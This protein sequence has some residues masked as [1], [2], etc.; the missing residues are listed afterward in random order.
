MRM[1]LRFLF[2]LA[3]APLLLAGC[4]TDDDLA[5]VSNRVIV[6][7]QDLRGLTAEVSD[8]RT[9][10][11]A[12]NADLEGQL[13]QTRDVL[14][15]IQLELDQMRQQLQRLTNKVEL[16]QQRGTT[17]DAEAK[18]LKKELA[19][20]KLRLDRIEATLTLPP[21]SASGQGQGE[22]RL[23]T[24]VP[25]EPTP[26]SQ[27]AVSSKIAPT[28]EAEAKTQPAVTPSAAATTPQAAYNV[29]EN[30]FKKGLYDPA[31]Q[32]FKEFVRT[33]PQSDLAPAA[34]FFAGECLYLQLKF[35]EAIL[36]YQEVV[37]KYKGNTRVS[38]ALL[39]QALAFKAIGDDATYRL[40]LQQIVKE[41]PDSYSGKE[42]KKK[43]AE[44]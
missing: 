35:E 28:A 36:E 44:R 24:T 15:D 20:A 12:W 29:A 9:K 41:Y 19:A 10:T 13:K 37:K 27:V 39:K 2:L 17:S 14:P 31:Y 40:L 30:L 25:P 22:E 23:A 38:I 8:L 7:Q 4:V 26:Q 18:A 3:A 6:N 11:K 16:S 34:Q 5:L 32:K 21:L 1:W 42:A 43:L 33:Y